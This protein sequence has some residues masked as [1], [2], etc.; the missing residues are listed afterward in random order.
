MCVLSTCFGRLLNPLPW[1]GM[2]MM[3]TTLLQCGL[4]EEELKILVEDNSCLLR[5]LLGRRYKNN[6][7]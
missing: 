2:R 7:A 3:P 6:A 5:N 4:S 1:E